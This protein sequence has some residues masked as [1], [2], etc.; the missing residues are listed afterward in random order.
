MMIF[1][2]NCIQIPTYSHLEARVPGI[3]FNDK[4]SGEKQQKCADELSL[5]FKTSQNEKIRHRGWSKTR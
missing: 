2:Y 5:S 1:C 3:Q 4:I